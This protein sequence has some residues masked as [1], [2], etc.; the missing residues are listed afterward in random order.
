MCSVRM[1]LLVVTALMWSC[2]APKPDVQVHGF[3]GVITP[4]TAGDVGG[5]EVTSLGDVN[6]QT[7]INGPTIQNVTIPSS[8]YPFGEINM[9][10]V[11]GVGPAWPADVF[12]YASRLNVD[13]D[14]T[15]HAQH[16][17]VAAFEAN[18]THSAGTNPLVATALECDATIT[19]DAASANDTRECIRM[20]HGDLIADEGNIALN[21]Q[22]ANVFL[23]G[24]SSF[25]ATLGTFFAEG[26]ANAIDITA[27]P[28]NAI[29]IRQQNSTIDLDNTGTSTVT[30]QNSGGGTFGGLKLS[31]QASAATTVALSPL[32]P[33]SV[34]HG[35]LGTG[36]TNLVGNITG[37][38]ANASVVLSYS[39]AFPSRSWCVATPNSNTTPEYIV[40]TNNASAP[41]FSCFNGT[42]GASAN[43]VDFTYYCFGQ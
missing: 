13:Y 30:L 32:P 10:N 24:A 34:N 28:T 39:S 17:G 37:I 19:G 29:R 14:T 23:S 36:S 2:N 40:V 6:T 7:T 9:V 3:A 15:S 38:G 31:G 42:T 43:C 20:F 5:G 16:A 26:S 22:S 18:V 27:N 21:G 11:S 8:S 4:T 35:S 1:S 41:T 25:I 33:T 12:I